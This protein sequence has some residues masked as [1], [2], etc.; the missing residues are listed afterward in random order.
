MSQFPYC[1]YA[2]GLYP[3]PSRDIRGP[4]AMG[5]TDTVTDDA[6]SPSFVAGRSLRF[7]SY[8]PPRAGAAIGLKRG[9]I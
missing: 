2:V 3:T 9:A 4:I 5:G 1:L 7:A 8:H 6:C